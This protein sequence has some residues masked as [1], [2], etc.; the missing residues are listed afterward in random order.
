MLQHRGAAAGISCARAA[1]LVLDSCHACRRIY[2]GHRDRRSAKVSAARRH[3]RFTLRAPIANLHAAG[4]NR[5]FERAPRG[6]DMGP[7]AA[8]AVHC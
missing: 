1:N 7:T 5:A 6:L 8:V 4:P 3:V 2:H